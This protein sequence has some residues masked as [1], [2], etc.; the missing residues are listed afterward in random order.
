ML[1]PIRFFLGDSMAF[2]PARSSSWL[3]GGGGNPKMNGAH[4]TKSRISS[5]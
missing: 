2:P 5:T 1:K 3:T 4:G